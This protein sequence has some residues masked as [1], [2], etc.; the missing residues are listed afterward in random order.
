MT[1]GRLDDKANGN[2]KLLALSDAAWRMWACGLIFCQNN[3]TDGF[4]PE[5]AIHAFGVRAKNKAAV[6][7]ELCRPLVPG[8]G[9]L[10][11]RV[12]GGFQVHDYMDV[13]DPKETV[14]AER[15][16]A[17]LRTERWRNGRNTNGVGDASRDESR[18]GV[19]VHNHVPQPEKKDSE[20]ANEH[21]V[22]EFPLRDGT[23]WLLRQPQLT[24]WATDFPGLDVLATCRAARS[25]AS[26]NPDKRKTA[27]GMPRFL[28]G[29]LLRESKAMPQAVVQAS[30][31]APERVWRCPHVEPCAQHRMCDFRLANPEKFPVKAQVAS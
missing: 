2:A 24:A 29:W 13:N 15:E 5:Q 12:D 19:H 22:L 30:Q 11:H 10:W 1:W 23:V 20:A 6:A 25:W 21:A 26:A 28:A 8:K 4:I 3:L 16:K 18:K 9:P 14:L 31:A 17:R 27:G 7:E